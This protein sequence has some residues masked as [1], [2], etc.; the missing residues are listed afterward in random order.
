MCLA[1]WRVPGHAV[2]VSHNL[3]DQGRD[4]DCGS[5][6]GPATLR[7]GG[8]WRHGCQDPAGPGLQ[9]DLCRSY[10][11]PGIASAVYGEG[12]QVVAVRRSSG[13]R[14]GWRHHR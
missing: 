6:L 8:Q 14:C 1:R 12:E 10:Q 13:G 5:R 3:K 7:T 9:R 4:C 2:P 11:G